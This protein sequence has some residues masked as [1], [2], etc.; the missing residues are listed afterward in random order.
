MLRLTSS[1]STQN[2]AFVSKNTSST[3]DV[4]TAYGVSHSSGHNSQYEQTSSY[5]LLANQS[6]CPQLDHEDLEQLDEF[7][8]EEMD[9]KWQVAMIS[10]RMKK[11][12]KKTG[13][14]LQFDAKEPVGFDKTKVECYSCHKTGHFAREC[15]TKG[16]QDSRR[17]DAWNSGNKDG[18]R[19][20]KQEDSKALVTIDGEGVDWTSHS[21]EEEED[22]ALMACNSSGSD[23]EVISCSKECKESYAELKKL[24]DKQR[25]Q[26]S[27]ASIEILSYTQALKK[28]EAQLVAHQQGQLWYEEKIRFMKIDLD[29]KTD[30]LTYHKKLLAEAE[31]EKEDLKAKVEK[32]HNSSK[33]LGKL[34]N[35]Q[36]SAN[37]KFGLGYG[38]HRYDGILSYENEVLQSVF[39]NKE[40]E[41]EKQPLY[42]RFVTAGGMHV[43]PPPMTG[44]YMPSGPDI[45]IDYSQFTYGPKQTQSSES[46]TQISEF[47]TCESNIST[48]TPEL[49][50]EPVVNESNVA[51]QPKVWSDAPII[52]EYESDSEDE[53]VSIPT[54]EQETPSFANQQVKTPRETVK[55]HFTH[56]KNPKVDKKE[57]GYG[58]TARACFVCGSLNHLIRD[59]DFHEKR[60]AKQAELNNRLNRNTSQREI[61]PIWNNVQRVNN[62]NQFVPTAV[63]TRTGKIPVNTARTSGTKN[64]STARHSFN[65][66]A[67]L[68][69]AAMKV[70]TV[71]PIVKRV[72]PTTVFHK[73][74]SPSSR[75]FNKTTTL[76]TNFSKQKVNTAKVNAVGAVGGKRETA[77]K[78]SAGCSW[79][80]KR[81]NWHNDYPHRALQN[82]GIVDSGCSRHMTGN[83]AYLAEYQDF[84]NFN[85][86]NIVPSGG[87]PC[88]IAKATI[89]ESNKWH[90]RL[91]HVNFKNLNKL[92]KGNLV[93]GINGILKD[94]I[95]QVE[96]Q[97]NQKVKT[98]RFDNGTEFKNKDVIKFCGSKGIKR[99]YSNARTPQQKGVAERKNRTL[100]EAA[101]TMLAD[102]F[103]PNTFWAEAVSTACYVLNRVLVTKLTF[104]ENKPNVARKG[105]TWLFD[106]DYLTDS[107]NYHPVRS[108]NQ[109]NIHTGQQEANHN[110]G[111][112]DI[113]DVG[114][115]EKEDESAQDCF[116]LP[117]WSSYS[118]TITPNLKTDEKRK[119]R[120]E[121]EQVFLDELERLKRQEKDANEGAAA[122]KKE[123]AQATES[124]NLQAGAA[125]A[126]STNIFS[127]VSTTAKASST[128]L[129]NT[130]SAPVSTASPHEGLSLS[131]PTNP[132]QDD[133]EIPPLE[134]I[135]Q[136]SPNG[137]F[138]NSSYDDEGAMADFTNLETIVNVSPIPTS[139]INSSHPSSLILGDPN[140]AVQ[141]RSKVNKS[142]GAHAFV[143]YV[144]VMQEE[145][146]QFKIQKVWILVDLPYGKK[147]IGIKW[148]YRN[149][150]DEKG[151]VVRNKARL[152]AQG[153]RQEEGIDYDEV[154]APVARI[155]AI[156][157][158]LAFASYM[159]FIVY[160]MDVKSA[161]L[162]GKIDEEVYVSQP[163]GFLDPKYPQKVYK[164]V[165]A[166]YGLHQAPRA[167]YATLFTFLFKNGYRR[168]TIDKTLFIKKDKHDIILVQVYVDDIIFGST[169]KSWCDEFEALMKSRFQMSS[170]GELTF[171]LGLQVKQKADGIFISQDKYVAE[172]LKKF[173]FSNVKTASTLIETQKPLDKDEEASDVDV[174]I[175]RSMI[176][177]LMYLTAFRPDI[178]F[179]VCACS[180]FQ[181]T[182]KSSHLSVV[183]RIFRRLSN[184][185]AGDLF[186]C[187]AKKSRP[188]MATS[189]TKAEYV[190]AASCCRVCHMSI[191]GSKLITQASK[192]YVGYE[193]STRKGWMLLL[194]HSEESSKAVH[195][196]NDSLGIT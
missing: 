148:V 178:M 80:P 141:T 15:R 35:T 11:F 85:L 87:L 20:G 17:R 180:R 83:K 135:Y 52:E 155:E 23:T 12:Y 186:S 149:K 150:K 146:L 21:E 48:E 14:K 106:L 123:F 128:N 193:E 165:K 47:D 134:D 133:S 93:R 177:S 84:R 156:R 26:L 104:L 112:E 16:N 174:H 97:L 64:V 81:H 88:L 169:K 115:F 110:A 166:L 168:G 13:R 136:N 119:G 41:L 183:K 171:F 130:V 5:S 124:L 170:M 195:I 137:I 126:S 176:G 19:S 22:Y 175:Y 89:D 105:P 162:Y 189:T 116:V 77:V 10:M 58:F 9:L 190:A 157:I 91:G 37:D 51:C 125:K 60:M 56:S 181:V 160:Q 55:N 147:A 187:N 122:L 27:D 33:N 173:D 188:I 34:L 120:R 94:F 144:D 70:N 42:D 36:M 127:T 2:V 38:D 109:A 132:E 25:A 31:K 28:V 161:F 86:E 63:L 163:P 68:T 71:K 66:Q 50:S 40:S 32:W 75:P 131:D 179:A 61:R 182:L 113:I 111:T 96:N 98:I 79:R 18:R 78:P 44:N 43:V 8:L 57:L 30:V 152:V 117:I 49:V 90:R 45:E 29:D 196:K 191:K 145:L 153:H 118:S 73:T 7:D 95:R 114:D 102:S 142:S 103:L 4:S 46:E 158:F 108:E 139:R 164:V 143:S 107:M 172:I 65:R 59:C 194:D 54:K 53:Y 100:I 167:W 39:M 140:S 192:D 3:N 74:H 154:F 67:V 6:S 151:V 82:K 121:E 24:Y 62:Q 129:V 92:V 185:L 138:T 159:G 1:S 99:E 76:R 72:R 184:F 69:S 101:R